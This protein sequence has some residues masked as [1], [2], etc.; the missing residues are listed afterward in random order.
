MHSQT[1]GTGA[2]RN[3]FAGSGIKN[4]N[5]SNKKT[6]IFRK[7]RKRKVHSPFIDN[8]WGSDLADMQLIS[9]SNAGI[10]FLPCVIDIFSKYA[11]VLL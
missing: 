7:F 6:P 2:T 1:L 5:I 11:W 4:E 3:K 10:R 9:K 8:I